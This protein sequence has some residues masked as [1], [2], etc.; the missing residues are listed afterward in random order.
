MHV[1]LFDSHRP[2]NHNNIIDNL[3]KIC[4]I[5]DGC[6]SFNE[7][8]NE[9][10]ARFLAELEE[11]IEDEEDEYDSEENSDAEEAK[12]ELKELRNDSDEEEEVLGGTHVEKRGED[13]DE[14]DGED[15]DGV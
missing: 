1:Y 9:E 3:K 11:D 14:E 4:V 2:Y 5:D 13:D 10:D 15:I 12:E 6:N 8:P 7:C